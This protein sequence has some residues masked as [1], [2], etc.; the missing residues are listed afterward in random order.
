MATFTPLILLLGINCLEG[1][2]ASYRPSSR[3]SKSQKRH[4]VVR[5]DSR[6]YYIADDMPPHVSPNRKVHPP[7]KRTPTPIPMYRQ[8]STVGLH[9]EDWRAINPQ[10]VMVHGGGGENKAQ[11]IDLEVRGTARIEGR[12]SRECCDR[13]EG[14]RWPNWI[15]C[16]FACCGGRR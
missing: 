11:N 6:E 15:A 14:Q 7:A 13:P 10:V 9:G 12:P 8:E 3:T 2:Q 1:S 4:K 16:F 5:M